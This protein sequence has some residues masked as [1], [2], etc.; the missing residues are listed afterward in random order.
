MNAEG[1]EVLLQYRQYLP[2]EFALSVDITG[3]EF[4]QAAVS[5]AV[6][7]PVMSNRSVALVCAITNSGDDHGMFGA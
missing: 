4:R 7:S 3:A 5:A 6:C 1:N 2:V